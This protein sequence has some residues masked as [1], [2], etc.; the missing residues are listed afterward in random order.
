MLGK[1]SKFGTIAGSFPFF[2]WIALERAFLPKVEPYV[3]CRIRR[4]SM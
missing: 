2:V 3:D 4:S 1:P